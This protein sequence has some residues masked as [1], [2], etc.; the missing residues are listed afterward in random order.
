M[1][2]ILAI[3]FLNMTTKTQAT[4]V[5]IKKWDDIKL[6]SFCSAKETTKKERKQKQPMKRHKI[7]ANG[8]YNEGLISKI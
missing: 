2:F 5:K 1:T 3:L 8:M 4:R 7:L 6:K